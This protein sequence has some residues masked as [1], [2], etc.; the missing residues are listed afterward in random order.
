MGKKGPKIVYQ[1]PLKDLYK[2]LPI[3][4]NITERVI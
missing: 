4:G 1:L 3:S 2:Y